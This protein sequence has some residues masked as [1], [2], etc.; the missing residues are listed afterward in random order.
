MRL[1]REVLYSLLVVI[2]ICIPMAVLGFIA[3]EVVTGLKIGWVLSEVLTK[4]FLDPK[5]R[6]KEER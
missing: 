2:P 1:L 4:W 3:R 5:H 6:R